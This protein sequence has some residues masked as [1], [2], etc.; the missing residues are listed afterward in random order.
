MIIFN[1]HQPFNI[2]SFKNCFKYKTLVTSIF[3]VTVLTRM[4]SFKNNFKSI[5]SKIKHLKI[6]D[7]DFFET[8]KSIRKIL[9]QFLKFE[10]QMCN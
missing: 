6:N 7:Y 9:K 10:D 2:M 5:K 1:T 8:F 3:Y 4:I